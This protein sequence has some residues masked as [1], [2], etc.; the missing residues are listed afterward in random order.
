MEIR[1]NKAT[2]VYILTDCIKENYNAEMLQDLMMLM[3]MSVTINMMNITM[4]VRLMNLMR[5]SFMTML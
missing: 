4:I 3:M 1:S 5:E 2:K